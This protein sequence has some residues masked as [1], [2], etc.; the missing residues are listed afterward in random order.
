M[1][2]I[3]GV[4]SYVDVVGAPS[5]E[6]PERSVNLGIRAATFREYQARGLFTAIAQYYGIVQ[7]RMGCAR[8]LFEGLKRP[9]MLGDDML[10]QQD[11]NVPFGKVEMSPLISD[12]SLPFPLAPIVLLAAEPVKASLRRAQ[13]RR[14]ALTEPAASGTH[15]PDQEGMGSLGSP[16]QG[17]VSTLLQRGTFLLCRDMGDDMR[18]DESV[19]VYTWRSSVDFEWHGSRQDGLPV[20]MVPP[21]GRVF[22]VLVRRE[23]PGESG[24]LGS[25]EKWNWITEDP[26]V[27]EAPIGWARRYDKSL[28]SR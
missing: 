1:R 23:V 14:A 27:P 26:R 9:L 8:H 10:W 24:C 21:A 4:G 18:A 6:D 3:R 28:W 20:Q 15:F 5:P 7:D 12:R 2:N 11:R 13:R 22:A 19:L 16:P 17:D 25:I